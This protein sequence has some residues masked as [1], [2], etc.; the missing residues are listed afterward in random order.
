MF[1][2]RTGACG[3]AHYLVFQLLG[4][5]VVSILE[6]VWVSRYDRIIANALTVFLNAGVYTLLVVFWYRRGPER[7]HVVGLLGLTV[8]YLVSYFFLFPTVDCP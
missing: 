1:H 8:V 2:R 3:T 5:T 7:W 4:G 6:M